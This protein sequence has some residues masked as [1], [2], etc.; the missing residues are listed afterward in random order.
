[1]GNE[2]DKLNHKR[3]VKLAGVCAGQ[4]E[5]DAVLRVLNTDWLAAGKEADAFE[6]EFA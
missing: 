2:L 5:I 3:I 6:R 1:M 4:E